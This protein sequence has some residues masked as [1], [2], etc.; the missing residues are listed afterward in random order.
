MNCKLCPQDFSYIGNTTNMRQHLKESHPVHFRE[1][2]SD[3]SSPRC[4]SA[5]ASSKVTVTD[6]EITKETDDTETS[7]QFVSSSSQQ[8]RISVL[9]KRQ[10]PLAHTFSRW[11]TI[12]D[13]VCYFIAKGMRSFQTVNEPGFRKRWNQDMSLQIGRHWPAITCTRFMKRREKVCWTIW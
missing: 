10:L 7:S 8:L 12:T 4:A 6:T 9:F 5:S 3:K 2:K 13:S 1:A 11:K